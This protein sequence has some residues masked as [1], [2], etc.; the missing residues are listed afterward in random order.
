MELR[1]VMRLKHNTTAVSPIIGVIIAVAITVI[2]ASIAY[3]WFMSFTE[4]TEDTVVEP[5]R[6]SAELNIERV[7]EELALKIIIGT[8]INWDDY[9]VVLNYREVDIPTGTFSTEGD[10]V[11]FDYQ[12]P[13]LADGNIYTYDIIDNLRNMVVFTDEVLA[14]SYPLEGTGIYGYVSSAIDGKPLAGALVF[15][16]SKSVLVNSTSTD[17]SGAYFMEYQGGIYALKVSVDPTNPETF[18]VEYSSF[19]VEVAL[20]KYYLTR[21]DVSLTPIVP[22]TATVKGFVYDLDSGDPLA[23]AMVRVTD[24]KL[25]TKVNI[26]GA[27]GYFE[28]SVV[29]ANI[30]FF[31]EL[32]G[33]KKFKL[34]FTI[35]DGEIR[36]LEV[37][38]EQ[39]PVETARIYG[40][41]FNKKTGEPLDRVNVF[42]ETS[43]GDN[44]S[45][46]DDGG[47]YEIFAA[48]GNVT[49]FVNTAGYELWTDSFEVL[50]KQSYQINIYLD[51]EQT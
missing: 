1:K 12:G 21:Y 4:Q 10:V 6:V 34:G 43:Y 50:D 5:I 16:Y 22:E 30:S 41:V 47:N 48:P 39:L 19:S 33:Y 7:H 32:D 17:P 8:N 46:S 3:V 15:L 35:D 29:T 23:G 14:Q 26:T 44:F 18:G 13:P 25:F 37:K 49:L 9:T 51:E 28:M 38:L 36:N 42:I 27:S 20:G 40:K 24:N 45:K 31:C 11:Y 2:L